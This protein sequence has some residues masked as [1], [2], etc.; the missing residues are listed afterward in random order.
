MV[1][2]HDIRRLR[3]ARARLTQRTRVAYLGDEQGRIH[4]PD[5]V[6]YVFVRYP[7][8][9]DGSGQQRLSPAAAVRVAVGA[10][11][12]PRVGL[13]VRVGVDA[14]GVDAVVQG[15]FS[16]MVEAGVNPLSS[17]PL[18][19][20]ARFITN[21]HYIPLKSDPVATGLTPSALVNARAWFYDVVEDYV[22]WFAG[23]N[24][25]A[26]KVDLQPFIPAANQHRYA[27]VWLDVVDGTLHVTASPPVSQTISLTTD[28]I[29]S[30]FADRPPDAVPIK[31]YYLADGAALRQRADHVD[32][33]TLVNVP[34]PVGAPNPV[35]VAQRVR[36]RRE[37]FYP[38]TLTVD[39]LL[40]V[41]GLVVVGL[42]PSSSSALTVRELDNNPSVSGVT[43]LVFPNASLSDLGGGVVEVSFPASSSLT[44]EEQDGSPSVSGVTKLKFDNAT[45]T[46]EGS[47][48]VSIANPP[49]RV[50]EVDSSPDVSPVRELVVP[51]NALT[52]LGAGAVQLDFSSASALTVREIDGNPNVSGVD[53]IEFTDTIVTD[54][55]GGVVR[56]RAAP[57]NAFYVTYATNLQLS[58]ATV[59]PAL[60][61]HPDRA[62]NAPASATFEQHFGSSNSGIKWLGNLPPT[63][64]NSNG[65]Y[66]SH[67]HIAESGGARYGYWSWA[68]TG[69]F[70]AHCKLVH[71]RNAATTAD[72]RF[73]LRSA[74]DARE[75]A[76]RVNVS[77]VGAI[78]RVGTTTTQV[79]SLNLRFS[80]FRIQRV[81]G[82]ITWWV[83]DDGRTW[84]FLG[85]TTFTIAVA[86]IGLATTDANLTL[87]CDWIWA[88]G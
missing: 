83:G 26:E 7:A 52:D 66:K 4:V 27:V 74:D 41:D 61:A 79:A 28:A 43:E 44:V 78:T 17:N 10:A 64:W 59:I 47:G 23:T 25:Q 77:S 15:D 36:A 32:L 19:P 14:D 50:R 37:Q 65:F 70:N 75:V 84:V 86:R 38:D 39:A 48:V 60:E 31:A 2:E 63:T 30:C 72:V 55:G 29:D 22:G 76:C 58:N 34:P 53:T 35:H 18:L 82:T 13:R 68:P 9:A 42:P 8:G 46:D 71:G 57:I 12:V 1:T 33:R 24:A 88:T 85:S 5:R 21:D 16:A 40:V 67:L 3:R 11:F 45:V 62:V 69:D 87:T 81:G 6:G 49:L 56:V 80:Y 54:V 51:N 73:S 20:D